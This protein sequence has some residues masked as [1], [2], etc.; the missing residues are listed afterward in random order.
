M[1]L[2]HQFYGSSS[3][4]SWGVP[5]GGNMC[6]ICNTLSKLFIYWSLSTVWSGYWGEVS[7]DSR[8]YKGLTARYTR[9][10]MIK[11]CSFHR[12]TLL[13]YRGNFGLLKKKKTVKEEWQVSLQGLQIFRFCRY[14]GYIGSISLTFYIANLL[15]EGCKLAS[16]NRYLLFKHCSSN[17]NKGNINTPS[18]NVV[19][20][21]EKRNMRIRTKSCDKFSTEHCTLTQWN[22]YSDTAQQTQ[23]LTPSKEEKN[24]GYGNSR[25]ETNRKQKVNKTNYICCGKR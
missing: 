8:L 19:L 5:Q 15:T 21:K 4:R 9:S 10:S 16:F 12:Q 3:L 11:G 25:T 23:A 20:E 24:S 2:A 1:S 22:T 6:L 7:I 18:H 17:E 13:Q 14:S